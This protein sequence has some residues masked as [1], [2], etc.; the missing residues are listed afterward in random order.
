MRFL[1]WNK[2][3]PEISKFRFNLA[4]ISERLELACPVDVHSNRIWKPVRT[5]IYRALE[6]THHFF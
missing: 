6:E 4:A 2:F 1:K 5:L 3:N